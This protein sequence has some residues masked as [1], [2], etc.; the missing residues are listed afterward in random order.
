MIYSLFLLLFTHVIYSSHTTLLFDYITPNN[1]SNN[2]TYFDSLNLK[3]RNCNKDKIA[4]V[5]HLRCIC[6][7]GFIQVSDGTCQKC[8]Q[9]KCKFYFPL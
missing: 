1:C 9:G 8:E 4:S 6:P 5:N 2:T 7:S 3:C